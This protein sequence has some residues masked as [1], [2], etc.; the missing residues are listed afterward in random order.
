[1]EYG[2]DG[3]FFGG[4]E[5]AQD[6]T[7]ITINRRFRPPGGGS[8]GE[9]RSFWMD[10]VIPLSELDIVKM[11]VMP[12]FKFKWYYGGKEDIKPDILNGYDMDLTR[13]KHFKR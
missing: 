1:M 2:Y 8:V 3:F 5:L 7:I 13:W 11:T 12:G 9:F 10:R 6:R 4:T